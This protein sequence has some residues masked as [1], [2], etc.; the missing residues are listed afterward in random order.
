MGS[1]VAG[2]AA[3]SLAEVKATNRGYEQEHRER[4]IQ[5]GLRAEPVHRIWIAAM[6]TSCSAP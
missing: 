1:A 4:G 6:A 2:P 3:Y 5:P